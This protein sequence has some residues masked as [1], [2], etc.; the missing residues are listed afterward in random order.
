MA[1]VLARVGGRIAE[2]EVAT[3]GSGG[4]PTRVTAYSVAADTQAL[5]RI[6]P[7]VDGLLVIDG[8]ILMEV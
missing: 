6:P 7:R 5:Y 8:G 1:K 3:G 4:V 2:V